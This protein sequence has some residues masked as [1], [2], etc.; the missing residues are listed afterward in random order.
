MQNAT[1]NDAPLTTQN[2]EAQNLLDAAS[3]GE[4]GGKL[5]KFKKG[6]YLI[7]DVLIPIGTEYLAHATAWTK[8]WI[9]F[10]DGKVERQLFRVAR[11][12]R[13]PERQE[14]G[15]LDESAW[16]FGPDGKR[17]DPWVFQ[18]LLPLENLETGDV[19]IFVTSSVGGRQAVSN[20]CREYAKRMLKG[21]S[22]QPIVR[23]AVGE[24]PT[25]N[26]GKVLR[27]DL[28]VVH[29][30]DAGGDSVAVETS[31]ATANTVETATA[32]KRAAIGRHNDMDDDIPF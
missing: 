3:E 7:G 32:P 6:Q 24:M 30:D 18:Y 25:K 5:L 31:L 4:G 9:K 26:F 17:S 20:V 19:A 1:T 8:A 2:N 29:W 15:S 10:S 14:L 13:P 12:E 16:P 23:L 27:P 21:H 28:E 11:A 22:G